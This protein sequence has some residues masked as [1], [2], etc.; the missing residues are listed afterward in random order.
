MKESLNAKTKIVRVLS[1]TAASLALLLAQPLPLWARTMPSGIDTGKSP[2]GARF[3]SGGVGLEERQ[4]MLKM[5]PG[6]DLKLAFADR[7]GDYLSDVVVTVDDAHGKQVLSTTT[8][9]PW[10][11]ISRPPGEI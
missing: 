11:Y 2:E 4:Q 3:M 7:R 1:L 9:G 5:A 10:L 8:A 6:Y